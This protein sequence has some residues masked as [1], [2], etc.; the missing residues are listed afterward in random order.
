MRCDVLL[1]TVALYDSH[2]VRM[3]GWMER[4]AKSNQKKRCIRFDVE[5]GTLLFVYL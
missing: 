5:M 2:L 3:N 4:E 1:K